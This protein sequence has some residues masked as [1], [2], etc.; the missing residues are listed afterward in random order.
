MCVCMYLGGGRIKRKR[1]AK[2]IMHIS[3]RGATGTWYKVLRNLTREKMNLMYT[4]TYIHIIYSVTQYN[5]HENV[6]YSFKNSYRFF[7][8]LR[9]YNEEEKK[10]Y[11]NFI[12]KCT[13]LTKF[14]TKN[15]SLINSFINI[16]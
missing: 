8:S 11:E 15:P 5:N 2:K 4:Y 7:L 16:N 3:T 14:C 12:L 1:T 9:K 10:K 13:L 6:C